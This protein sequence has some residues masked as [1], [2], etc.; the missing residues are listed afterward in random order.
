LEILYGRYTVNDARFA[1]IYFQERFHRRSGLSAA[2][3]FNLDFYLETKSS[4]NRAS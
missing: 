3:F 2:L 1:A 4:P